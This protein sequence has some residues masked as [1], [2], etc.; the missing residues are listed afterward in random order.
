VKIAKAKVRLSFDD[1]PGP[2]TAELLDALSA[3]RCKATFFLL[4][5]H[6]KQDM[7]V[8]MRMIREGHT[9]GNHT[10]SHHRPATMTGEALAGE[11]EATDVL[12]REAYRRVGCVVPELIPV[13]LPYGAQTDDPRL[14]A[15]KKLARRHVGWTAIF[16]DW[17][18]PAPPATRLFEDMLRHIEDCVSQGREAQLCL[19][20]SSR[21]RESRPA[22]V[23]AVRLLLSSPR[24]HALL[25]DESR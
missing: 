16:D 11:L 8:A 3:A 25:T 13:R 5:A 24:C 18:R 2:S 21:H 10:Y 1:G 19:H 20:D 17:R 22:T 12:I 4:G 23:E 6:L 14:T 7:P 15:L 9:I